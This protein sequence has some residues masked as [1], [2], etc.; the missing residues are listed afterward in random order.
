[1]QNRQFESIDTQ[2]LGV[3]VDSAAVQRAYSASLGGLPYPVLADFH[4]KGEMSDSFG[5]YNEERGVSKRAIVII[6]KQGIIKFHQIYEG[7]LPEAKDIL[8]EVKA[9]TGTE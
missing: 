5:V 1:L 3:S 8:E 6:D 9:V 2:V 4:P 7:E